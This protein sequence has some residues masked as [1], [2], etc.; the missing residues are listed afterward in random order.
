MSDEAILSSRSGTS[1]PLGKRTEDVR[2]KIPFE[3]KQM[4]LRDV[5][6]HIAGSESE[7]I[8]EI[9]MAHYLGKA[10]LKKLND[11]R[12]DRLFGTGQE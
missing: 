8:C 4:L 1:N 2:G 3:I 5:A 6:D 10:G 12:L 9:I 11:D 7:L